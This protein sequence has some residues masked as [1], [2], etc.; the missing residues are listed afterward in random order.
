V[1]RANPTPDDQGTGGSGGT[2]STHHA[3]AG[4]DASSG[5]DG[6]IHTGSGGSGGNG[7]GDSGRTSTEAGRF[8]RDERRFGRRRRDRRRLQRRFRRRRIGCGRR[9]LPDGRGRLVRRA[10]GGSTQD[11]GTAQD[12]GTIDTAQPTRARSWTR[13]T[14]T[15]RS[16][17]A[18]PTRA[19]PARS[20]RASPIRLTQMG[21]VG[22][23]YVTG[24]NTPQLQ[25]Y[26][27]ADTTSNQ[28]HFGPTR[29][30]SRKDATPSGSNTPNYAGAGCS[31][32][33]GGACIGAHGN[34]PQQTT[35]IPGRVSEHRVQ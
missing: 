31:M 17:P 33:S 13:A 12:T 14:P 9:V 15:R 20:R 6:A 21:I 10:D 27:A 22:D 26:L 35:D 8:G 16:T 5:S 7:G 1:R 23:S 32:A 24:F 29:T 25:P 3:D 4:V 19:M 11:T 30:T 2:G 28:V 34:V 18:P